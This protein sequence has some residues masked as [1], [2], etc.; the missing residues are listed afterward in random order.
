MTTVAAVRAT[1]SDEDGSL[2]WRR[3][4]QDRVQRRDGRHSQGADEVEDVVAVLAAPDPVLVL[5][6]DDVDAARRARE[7]RAM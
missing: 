7:R 5:D 2:A 4:T 6:R 3:M 1:S